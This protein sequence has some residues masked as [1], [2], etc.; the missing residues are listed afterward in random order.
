MRSFC[1]E[2]AIKTNFIYTDEVFLE[3]FWVK[4]SPN[5]NT[6][7]SEILAGMLRNELDSNSWFSTIR[8]CFEAKYV[9]VLVFGLSETVVRLDS[10]LGK[11]HKRSGMMAKRK[12]R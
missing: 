7:Q 12:A 4:K 2:F 8:I 6:A 1:V 10:D 3:T 11:F 9:R 5:I